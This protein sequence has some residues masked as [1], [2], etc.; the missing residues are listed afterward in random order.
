MLAQTSA[1]QAPQGL[2]A[3]PAPPSGPGLGKLGRYTLQSALGKGGMAEVFL[4]TQD[5]PAGFSKQV[6]IKR[7][8]P[9]L[10]KN[11]K[12]VEMF[13]REAKI[14][15]LLNH[16]NVVQVFE[17]G[18]EGDAYFIAM[19]HIDGISLQRAA[20]R[21][22][23]TLTVPD[24]EG[25]AEI[26]VM[27]GGGP[28]DHSGIGLAVRVVRVAIPLV[29]RLGVEGTGVHRADTGAHR[30]EFSHQ[31]VVEAMHPLFAEETPRH[32]RLVRDDDDQIAQRI[33]PP[34][35]FGSSGD[36]D[37]VLIQMRIAAVLDQ[38]AVAIQEDGGNHGGSGRHGEL[39]CGVRLNTVDRCK[40][41]RDVSPFGLALSAASR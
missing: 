25:P 36:E 22:K 10:A 24:H 17:L 7:S 31:L 18:Q 26:D 13:L 21:L 16:N 3:P 35:G 2:L 6:V 14:A 8:D 40:A 11:P 15:A 19:E 28:Q 23:V 20:R 41:Q 5:G 34:H 12:F 29:L 9:E 32:A 1:L 38:D 33:Q 39:Q 4:A 27:I 30:R 37:Q